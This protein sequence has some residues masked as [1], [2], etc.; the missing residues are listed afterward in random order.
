ME[1]VACKKTVSL[2]SFGSSIPIEFFPGITAI[3]ADVELIDL[4]ISSAREI[5]RDDFTPGAGSSS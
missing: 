3:L 1:F 4:D 2:S 5:T